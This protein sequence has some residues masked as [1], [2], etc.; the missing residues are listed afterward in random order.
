MNRFKKIDFDYEFIRNQSLKYSTTNF[1]LK[2][3]KFIKSIGK[4][5]KS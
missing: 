3:K 5:D 4:N 2:I 1:E